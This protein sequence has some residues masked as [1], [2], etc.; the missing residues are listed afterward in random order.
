MIYR[1]KVTVEG[2]TVRGSHGN[3][4]RAM[5]DINIVDGQEVW[6]DG[7]VIYGHQTAGYQDVPVPHS[8]VM[9]VG[10]CY[11]YSDGLPTVA[12]VTDYNDTTKEISNA[13]LMA[14]VSDGLHSYGAK[15]SPNGRS[16][17]LQWYNLVTG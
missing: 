8:G 3:I 1:D 12:S 16:D 7:K 4:L 17:E 6:T 5:G 9:P 13:E 10:L 15:R 14:F 2:S 11:D